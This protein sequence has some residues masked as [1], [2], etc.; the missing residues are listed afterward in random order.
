[1]TLSEA[2]RAGAQIRPQAFGSYFTGTTRANACSCAIGAAYEASF[3]DSPLANECVD[4]DFDALAKLYP[5]L[6]SDELLFCPE[7]AG[8]EVRRENLCN[9]LIHLNDDH[10]WPRER[11]AEY[12]ERFEA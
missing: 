5:L 4:K 3:T 7:C 1:M 12:V 9:M 8:A 6:N 2:I 10:K 11:I